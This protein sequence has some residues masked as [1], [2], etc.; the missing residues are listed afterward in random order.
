MYVSNIQ[1]SLWQ[2]GYGHAAGDVMMGAIGTTTDEVGNIVPLTLSL[3]TLFV[4]VPAGDIVDR[5]CTVDSEFM[6][7]TMPEVGRALRRKF[8]WL[9]FNTCIYL[10]MDNAGGHESYDAKAHY[11]EAFKKDHNVKIIWQVP[12][13][14]ETNLLDLG[15]WMSIQ[16]TVENLH[17]KKGYNMKH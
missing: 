4:K 5:D 7:E 13:S 8:S 17:H 14:P 9:P 3:L 12:R 11:T 16:A 10:V 1:H 6:L 2:E 15:I